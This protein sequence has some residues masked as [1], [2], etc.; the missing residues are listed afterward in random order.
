MKSFVP[1][2]FLMVAAT[3]A[4]AETSSHAKPAAKP[5]TKTTAAKPVPA[6]V[7][8]PKGIP[9]AKGAVTTAFT[10]RVQEI[11]IGTGEQAEFGKVVRIL[12]TGWRAADGVK[13][14][15]SDEHRQP[16]MDKDGKPEKDADGK[17]KVGDSMPLPFQAGVGRMIPGVD[18]GVIGMKVGGKRRLFIPYQL[19]YGERD[20]PVRGDQPGIPSKSDLIFDIELVS[21][22]DVPAR[23]P[24]M[25]RPG[26]AAPH[27]GQ[28]AVPPAPATATPNPSSSTPAASA[29]A[30]PPTP[31]AP[32]TPPT[33]DTTTQPK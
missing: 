4:G 22:S 12:Y 11:K 14:D 10:Q 8:L 29:P 24:G 31:A 9:A 6:W 7:K 21:V 20:I 2:L 30:T 5:A 23:M 13:F 27:P 33:P 16:V 25:M 1:A 19:A 3:L 26:A 32:A 18:R 17:P 28:P 15:S